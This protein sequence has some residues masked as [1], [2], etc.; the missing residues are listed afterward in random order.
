MLP[1][2]VQ[3]MHVPMWYVQVT[4]LN[5]QSHNGL[6]GL[7]TETPLENC[8]IKPEVTAIF[9]SSKKTKKE[10]CNFNQD[11]DLAPGCDGTAFDQILML[12]FTA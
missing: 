2:A 12:R 6:G 10:Y 8:K 1:T 9:F 3:I 4:K 11:W 5:M 7:T